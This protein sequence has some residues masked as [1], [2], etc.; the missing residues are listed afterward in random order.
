MDGFFIFLSLSAN[1]LALPNCACALPI[2]SPAIPEITPPAIADKLP[3][4]IPPAILVNL[5]A[6]FWDK[7]PIVPVSDA[8]VL[9]TIPF[10]SVVPLFSIVNNYEV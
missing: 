7:S 5:D 8:A 4:P 2:V 1:S 10:I 6:A 3:G 9:P